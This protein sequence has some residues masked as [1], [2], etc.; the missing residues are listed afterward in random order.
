MKHYTAKQKVDIYT[1]ESNGEQMMCIS[2][3]IVRW[4]NKKAVY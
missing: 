2:G 4:V 1:G 3:Y